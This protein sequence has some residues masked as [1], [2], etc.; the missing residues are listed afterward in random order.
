MKINLKGPDLLRYRE[1]RKAKQRFQMPDKRTPTQ[2]PK[3]NLCCLTPR[4]QTKLMEMNSEG[5]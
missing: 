1:I 2:E 3:I 5:S 4:Q